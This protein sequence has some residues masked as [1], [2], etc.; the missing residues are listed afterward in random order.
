MEVCKLLYNFTYLGQRLSNGL[1]LEKINVDDAQK[2]YDKVKNLLDY[3]LVF[4][5]MLKCD[6]K[7]L[8]NKENYNM[9]C[10]D[11]YII[12]DTIKKILANCDLEAVKMDP[13]KSRIF[14]LE[15]L[16]S[17]IIFLRHNVDSKQIETYINV[18]LS[19]EDCPKDIQANSK[20]ILSR[21]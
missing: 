4:K 12:D 13:K 11:L 15:N 2:F 16:F 21:K 8:L 3:Y 9:L 18:A 7:V 5:G 20:Y 19:R 10:T 14:L 6:P 1:L 17:D